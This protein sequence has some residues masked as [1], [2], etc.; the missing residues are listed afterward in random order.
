M[1]YMK[2]CHQVSNS[3]YNV[4]LERA[5]N[6]DLTGAAQSLKRSLHFNKYNTDARNLLGLIYYEIGEVADALVQWVISMNLQ[7]ENNRADYYL[8]ELQRKPGRLEAASQNVKKYNQALWQAK[9]GSDDLAV[10]QL[11]RVVESNPNFLKAHLLLAL[12]YMNHEDYPKAGKSLYKVLQIDKNNPKALLYMSIVKSNTGKAEIERR[13]LKNAFSHRQMQDDDIII[14]PTYQENTG[15]QTIINILVG[16]V[17]GAAVIFFL[18][19]PA[20]T[21]NTEV[22][23]KEELEKLLE[24]LNTRNL[25]LADV[26]VQLNELQSEKDAVDQTL[27][28][29]SDDNGGVLSQYHT[30]IGILQ[31]YKDDK[32]E[33]AVKLYSTL[34]ASVITDSGVQAVIQ[35]IKADME[36]NGY[37]VLQTLG[38][39][40]AARGDQAAA[41]D[42]YQKSLAIHGDN[43]QILFNMAVIYKN[44]DEKETSNDLFGQVI[45]NYPDTE[46]AV[47]AKEERGY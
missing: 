34:D 43:P 36:T 25:E 33:D 28:T 46:L 13:K 17:L 12:L 35:V 6:R 5:E 27:A 21:V 31:A 40:A 26:R 24:E 11:T 7:P 32:F 39:E 29:L 42:Y 15:W 16:L 20:V 37:Q 47:K 4:G 44:M 1:D 18:V 38:E 22:R 14:P 45:M 30:L 2:K 23:H 41:L 19:L 8:D 10:L 9:G 3:Y